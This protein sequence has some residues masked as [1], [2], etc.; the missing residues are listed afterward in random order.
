MIC[1][2]NEN[3]AAIIGRY[4]TQRRIKMCYANVHVHVHHMHV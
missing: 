2:S 4:F 1:D 3:V